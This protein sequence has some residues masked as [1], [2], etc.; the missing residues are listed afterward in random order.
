MRGGVAAVATFLHGDAE[1]IELEVA[2]H[3]RA[4]GAMVSELNLPK[5]ALIAAFVRDGNPQIGR[6][7]SRLR[8]R[9]RVVVVAM[10]SAVDEVHGVLG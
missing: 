5:N 3:S 9:D 10:P 6:G 1:I 8:A 4:D 2:E 7:R